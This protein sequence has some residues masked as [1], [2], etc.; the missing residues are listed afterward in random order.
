MDRA[1]T[2]GDWE[3]I[4]IFLVLAVL[5]AGFVWT[6]QWLILT[7]V[8]GK[9]EVQRPAHPAIERNLSSDSKDEP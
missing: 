5:T 3:M 4:R 6:F 9:K 2:K 7:P 8:S 1:K